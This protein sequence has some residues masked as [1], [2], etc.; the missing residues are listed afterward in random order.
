LAG[1]VVT[2]G[3]AKSRSELPWLPYP[4]KDRVIINAHNFTPPGPVGIGDEVGWWCPSLDD[5]GNGTLTFYDLISGGISG[6]LNNGETGDWVSDTASGGVRAIT[7][8]GVNERGLIAD[9][10]RFS[11]GNGSTDLPFSVSCW[12]LR[13]AFAAAGFVGKASGAAVGEWYLFAGTGEIVFRVID[14]SVGIAV[15]RRVLVSG[16]FT[17]N[18]WQHLCCTYSG[19][20]G[21][22][23]L[24]IYLNGSRLDDANSSAGAGTYVAM[25]NTS[26]PVTIGSRGTAAYLNGRWD[27]VRIF[28]VDLSGVA[29]A[30]TALA[31]QRGYQL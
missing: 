11:F 3:F 30:I 19:S 29:G 1:V 21:A 6:S 9:D 26:E 7:L 8:D 4:E 2:P 28:D 16:N 17:E 27:D 31:S 13:A 5:T 15:G 24:K 14:T 12:V 10:N 20:G 18:A 25:E 23:G 22:A